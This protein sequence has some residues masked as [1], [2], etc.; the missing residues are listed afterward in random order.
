MVVVAVVVEGIMC[1]RVSGATAA[2]KT[3]YQQEL[4]AELLTVRVIQILWEHSTVLQDSVQNPA[5]L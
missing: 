5:L 4:I 3:Y 2:V 1:H